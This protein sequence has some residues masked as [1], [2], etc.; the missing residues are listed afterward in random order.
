M[1][2]KYVKLD[3]CELQQDR[4]R[5]APEGSD[6]RNPARGVGFLGYYERNAT[7]LAEAMQRVIKL[8]ERRDSRTQTAVLKDAL[9]QEPQRKPSTREDIGSNPS[10][11]AGFVV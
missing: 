10:T 5:A 4:W 3:E 9:S 11:A 6:P 7:K 1:K 8:R 2:I